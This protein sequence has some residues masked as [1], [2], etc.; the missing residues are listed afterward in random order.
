MVDKNE[1]T[2]VLEKDNP[3]EIKIWAIAI[4][5]FG[6]L[7]AYGFHKHYSIQREL[8]EY[9]NWQ[10]LYGEEYRAYKEQAAKAA[11][12]RKLNPNAGAEEDFSPPTS[13]IGLVETGGRY[14]GVRQK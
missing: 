4:V 3:W 5:V 9:E 11:L 8:K 2:D 10:A 6:L 1:E 7:L 14:D 12:Q 13:T